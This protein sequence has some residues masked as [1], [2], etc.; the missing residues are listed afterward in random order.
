[1]VPEVTI[2]AD[3][4]AVF[5]T[6]DGFIRATRLP[7]GTVARL[8]DQAT[9][10]YGLRDRYAAFNGSDAPTASFTFETDQRRKT[11]EVYGMSLDRAFPGELEH[12]TL[13]KLRVLYRSITM[14]LPSDSPVVKPDEV[15]IITRRIPDPIL[16]D[17]PEYSQV[18]KVWPSELVGHLRGSDALAA[19]QL[20]PPGPVDLYRLDGRVHTVTVRPVLPALRLPSVTWPGGVLPRHPR[21]TVLDAPGWPHRFESP[22]RSEQFEWYRREMG[23]HG[24]P[25][26]APGTQEERESPRDMGQGDKRPR[27]NRHDHL[28]CDRHHVPAHRCLG[29][30]PSLPRI[31]LQH[32]WSDGVSE[33]VRN[34]PTGG[35]G[36]V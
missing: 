12:E 15:T 4:Y 29:W 34:T 6:S 20:L 13:E 16:R 7:S 3:G 28:L 32:L 17:Y 26:L 14:E 9:L 5:P 11:V 30:G 22:I 27:R 1:M 2:W 23:D 21:A 31:F 24:R 36:M 35:P 19:V 33:D 8:L 18:S 10:L 25:R